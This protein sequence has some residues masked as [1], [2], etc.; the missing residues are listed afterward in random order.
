MPNPT[1]IGTRRRP[2]VDAD[3]GCGVATCA[4]CYEPD[5]RYGALLEAELRASLASDRICRAMAEYGYDLAADVR[6]VEG[7]VYRA[8]KARCEYETARGW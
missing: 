8:I 5:P 6:R 4:D 7:R 3:G 2:G 1:P